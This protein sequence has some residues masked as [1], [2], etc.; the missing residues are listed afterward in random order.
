MDDNDIKLISLLQDNARNT[1]KKLS[2][3]IFLSSPAVAARIEKLQRD[4]IITGY[5]AD[6]NYE[7]LGYHIIAFINTVTDH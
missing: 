3:Q 7:K 6:V 5:H 1:L 2:E 4:G